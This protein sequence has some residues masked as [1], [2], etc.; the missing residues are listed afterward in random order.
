MWLSIKQAVARYRRY[1]KNQK[2]QDV[3][4]FCV[5]ENDSCGKQ[6]TLCFLYIFKDDDDEKVLKVLNIEE[7][8]YRRVNLEKRPPIEKL[9]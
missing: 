8:P 1:R 6:L 5:D 7:F 2:N 3:R 9:L 4:I